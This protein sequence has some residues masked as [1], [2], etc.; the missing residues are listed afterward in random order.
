MDCSSP[1]STPE[2]SSASTIHD[3]TSTRHRAKYENPNLLHQLSLGRFFD[4][5]SA[6]L[7]QLSPSELFEF[8]C[9]EGYLLRELKKRGTSLPHVV[10]I[11][12][13]QDAIEEARRLHPEWQFECVNLFDWRPPREKFHTVLA[14]QVL[15]HI[16]NPEP[17]LRKLVSLADRY[18]VLTVP[19][20]PWFQLLNFLRGRDLA[21][22]GNH[23]EHV[24]RWSKSGFEKFVSSIASIEQVDSSFPFTI[25]VARTD[26]PAC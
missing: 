15:E 25:I 24:N 17:V 3:D 22:L 18:L 10:G 21:R 9:G 6:T 7:T 23:P 12:L 2:H 13:R 16:P 20:E 26:R 19:R 14:S 4:R 11:D 5:L 1:P 8:G